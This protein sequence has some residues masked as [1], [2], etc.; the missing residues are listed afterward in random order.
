MFK[1]KQTDGIALPLDALDAIHPYL[2]LCVR[3]YAIIKNPLLS[4]VSM[5]VRSKGPYHNDNEISA[6]RLAY[7]F[8]TQNDKWPVKIVFNG[9]EFLFEYG[10]KEAGRALATHE[11]HPSYANI[12]VN[13]PDAN[14]SL[15]TADSFLLIKDIKFSDALVDG[16]KNHFK[17]DEDINS[18]SMHEKFVYFLSVALLSQVP[19]LAPAN[20]EGIKSLMSCLENIGEEITGLL[21]ARGG[22]IEK[23]FFSAAT[24]GDGKQYALFSRETTDRFTNAVF[25]VA[26]KA[27]PGF[28]PLAIQ[29][30]HNA[31]VL[32]SP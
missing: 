11:V 19:T 13:L 27:L 32:I 9:D 5:E 26:Q 30:A 29:S 23:A 17:V 31:E 21:E 14:P 8:R 6:R 16:F 3:H 1:K 20:D 12:T 24:I 10:R 22:S 25:S 18:K 28:T 4:G 15:L 2:P 7:S